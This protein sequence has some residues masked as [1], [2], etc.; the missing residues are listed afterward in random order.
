MC[1]LEAGPFSSDF[2]TRLKV[3]PYSAF[4]FRGK[5]K[6]HFWSADERFH[7]DSIS[8]IRHVCFYQMIMLCCLDIGTMYTLHANAVMTMNII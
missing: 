2:L 1:S 4:D 8:I 6:C 5:N 7:L 3:E